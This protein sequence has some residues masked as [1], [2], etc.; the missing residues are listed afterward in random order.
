[1]IM[2]RRGPVRTRKPLL[3]AAVVAAASVVLPGARQASANDFNK[4]TGDTWNNAANWSDATI[5]NAVSANA[6]FTAI[7]TGN[8]TVTVDSGAPGF[9][10]GSMSVDVNN[11]NN[12][13]SP[14][15]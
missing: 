9:T 7:N 8:R 13:I 5:P 12:T 15:A 11:F 3:T 2:S 14:G 10:I 4:T 6:S 1:M